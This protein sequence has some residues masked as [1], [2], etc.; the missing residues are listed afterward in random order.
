MSQAQKSSR[1][2]RFNKKEMFQIVINLCADYYL[3]QQVLVQLL[4]RK[5][6][7]LRKN[8]LKPLL[9][10]GK[11]TLAFPRAPTHSKQ[12]YT[13]IKTKGEDD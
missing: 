13:T 10:Q 4:D 6:L 7:A 2:K 12:A 9:D 11:L 3:T 8:T 1:R 5:P